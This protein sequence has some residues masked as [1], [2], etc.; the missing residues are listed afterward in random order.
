[1]QFYPQLTQNNDR[2]LLGI[3]DYTLIL[4][5]SLNQKDPLKIMGALQLL[6]LLVVIHIPYKV[7]FN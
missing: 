5:G 3:Q 4:A 6:Q 2:A 7:I 1:M